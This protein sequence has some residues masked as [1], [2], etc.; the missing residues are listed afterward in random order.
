VSSSNSDICGETD[1]DLLY[2]KQASLIGSTMATYAEFAES[3][4][5]FSAASFGQWWTGCY[6]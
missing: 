2:W 6:R 4:A 5:W 1:L 3:W